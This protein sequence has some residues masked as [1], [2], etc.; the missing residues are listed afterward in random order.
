MQVTINLNADMIE[1]LEKHREKEV[2]K[3]RSLIT[4]YEDV[5][6]WGRLKNKLFDKL[7]RGL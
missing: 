5:D 6:A 3:L 1:R 7:R 4:K 2:V